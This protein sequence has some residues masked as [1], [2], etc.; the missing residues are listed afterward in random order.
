M[1]QRGVEI[2][3]EKIETLIR[4]VAEGVG[5]NSRKIDLLAGEVGAIKEGNTSISLNIHRLDTQLQKIETSLEFLEKEIREIRMEFNELFSWHEQR[6]A[7]LEV[8]V[9]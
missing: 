6:I 8:G 7:Y 2:V 3:A 5:E 9:S 1:D 4:I